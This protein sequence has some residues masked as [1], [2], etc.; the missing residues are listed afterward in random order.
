MYRRM[1]ILVAFLGMCGSLY[2]AW[3]LHRVSADVLMSDT[4]W[5]QPWPYPD[6]WLA[7]LND[8]YDARYPAAA[9]SIKLHAEFPRVRMTVA[10]ALAMCLLTVFM[11]LATHAVRSAVAY[12][13]CTNFTR[14]MLG[15]AVCLSPI[16]LMAMSFAIGLAYSR[17]SKAGLTLSVMALL[18]GAVN[19]YFWFLRPMAYALR[20]G[21]MH[22]TRHVSG[23]PGVGSVLT[24]CAAIFSFPD[25]RT[26]LVGL[27]ATALDTG[28]L[29][30]F[31]LMTWRDRSLWDGQPASSEETKA[32]D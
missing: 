17:N 12:D 2:C 7:A 8:W 27:M 11:A 22:G 13:G 32:V 28:G 24:I 18:L 9:G 3:A 26:G 25:W 16:V 4:A 19:F 21:S 5:P 10:R 30:W 29:P 31:A 6:N 23:I 1:P 15:L 14:R 20:H